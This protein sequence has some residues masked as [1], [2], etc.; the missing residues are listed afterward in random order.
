MVRGRYTVIGMDGRRREP[1]RQELS[2]STELLS[3]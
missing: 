1:W 3:I 2:H